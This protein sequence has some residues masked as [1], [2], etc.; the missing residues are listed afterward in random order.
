MSS[1]QRHPLEP[2]PP[3]AALATTFRTSNGWEDAQSE[4]RVL[5]KKIPELSKD[6]S[7]N[8][9][10]SYQVSTIEVFNQKTGAKHYVDLKKNS[11]MDSNSY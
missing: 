11:S 1:L 8:L 6:L 5:R 2:T 3:W 7:Y 9:F 4:L 10:N